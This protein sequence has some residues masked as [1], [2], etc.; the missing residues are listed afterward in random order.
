MHK[1]LKCNLLRSCEVKPRGFTLI[2]LLV[3]IAI[4]AILA[5]ILLPALNSARERGRTASCISNLNSMGKA[6]AMY[7]DDNDGN[8]P[9]HET[10]MQANN[11][12]WVKETLWY[13]IAQYAEG[14]SQ[15]GGGTAENDAKSWDSSI[16][17]CPS[18]SITSTVQY[19]SSYAGVRRNV[20]TLREKRVD[21]G[22]DT[23]ALY[24]PIKSWAN[25]SSIFVIAD[26]PHSDNYKPAGINGIHP[27]QYYS[28]GAYVNGLPFN[29]DHNS[30][31]IKESGASDDKNGPWYFNGASPRHG[32]KPNILF[33]DGHAAN[34]EEGEF[35]KLEHWKVMGD[36]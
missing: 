23:L 19:P 33:G 18:D 12:A 24:V 27:P 22:G 20:I 15:W 2:E 9:T 36:I 11:I 21:V 5:A 26:A 13:R 8:Q 10:Y 34:V 14:S 28:D 17:I 25:T 1:S 6:L 16:F 35:V 30:N 4:I 31:G 3:V 29:K 32:E 7:V